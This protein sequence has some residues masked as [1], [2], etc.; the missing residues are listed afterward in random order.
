M[1]I[2]TYIIEIPLDDSNENYNYTYLIESDYGADFIKTSIKS[3]FEK[4]ILEVAKKNNSSPIGFIS[5]L[6]KGE[7]ATSAEVSDIFE[8]ENYI[9]SILDFINDFDE[10]MDFEVYTLEEWI[11]IKKEYGKKEF[12]TEV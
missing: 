5:Y 9:F 8:I 1:S 12:D 6:F 2:Q 7:P 3:F 4:Y 10:L 11:E